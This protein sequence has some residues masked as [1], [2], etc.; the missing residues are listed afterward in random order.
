MIEAV[1]RSRVPVVAVDIPSGLSSD[2]GRPLGT[3][4][5][6]TA[7]VT[8]GLPKLGHFLHPGRRLCG[9]L[10]VVDI[11][12]PSQVTEKRGLSRRVVTP[13]SLRGMLPPRLP[14]AH[15]G[16]FGH[17]LVLAGSAG[18]TG[19]GVM[20]SEAA[21]RV[22]A[23][24][25]TLGVPRSLNLAMEAR[26]T[27]V[28]TLPLSETDG[29]SLARCALPEIHSALEGKTCVAL[30]PGLSTHAETQELVCALAR[31]VGLPMVI[32]ADGLNALAGYPDALQGAK[33]ARILTPHPGEMGRLLGRS[34]REIQE[35]RLAAAQELSRR[36][37]AF[38]VLKGAGTVLAAPDGGIRLVPTGNPAMAS[39]GMGD[40]L[41]GILTGLLAQGMEPLEAMSLGT[42][43]HG[44]IADQ[45]AE[46]MGGR[47]LLATDLLARSPKSLDALSRGDVPRSWPR[48]AEG[49]A[50]H[51]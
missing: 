20:A 43:L 5:E 31:E 48:S 39:A 38:V 16:H 33:A 10:W 30:G 3:A 32:D 28:M 1:N 24:L 13:R 34:V 14:D 9:D 11:G 17:A 27:E 22:G 50:F 12:I 49:C 23:G 40:V 18:K 42:Y 21:L 35:D 37:G 51:A 45:W 8:F 46:E 44:W 15:K 25:V 19:A 41:T 36:S 4:V 47:G 26:L 29:Q 6:A 2:H 7:T